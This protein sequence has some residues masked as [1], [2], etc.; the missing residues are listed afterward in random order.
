MWLNDITF[1]EALE[2]VAS[3]FG[4]HLGRANGRPPGKWPRD[5]IALNNRELG[6]KKFC[7]I[8]YGIDPEQVRRTRSCYAKYR[9]NYCYVFSGYNA[10][11]E[12]SM[13]IAY[14]VTDKYLRI[15]TRSGIDKRKTQI[16]WGTGDAMIIVGSVQQL[17]DASE[18]WKCEGATDALALAATLPG[19]SVAIANMCGAGSFPAG[20]EALLRDKRVWVVGDHDANRTGQLGA[21][22][23]AGLIQV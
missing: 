22:K 1:R 8:R 2:R 18:V 16:V 13:G 21:Y 10:K 17:R 6:I 12:E 14:P 23:A 3:R 15:R 7:S 5:L 11:L 20:W 19:G 9:M 4:I